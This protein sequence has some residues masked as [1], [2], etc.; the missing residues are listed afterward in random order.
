MRFIRILP[1]SNVRTKEGAR[2]I[3]EEC[4]DYMRA[5]FPDGPWHFT[6]VMGEE[7]L[8]LVSRTFRSTQDDKAMRWLV[9]ELEQP[10]TAVTVSLVK[11]VCVGRLA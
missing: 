10:R 7:F 2:A 8:P 5:A 1:S 4:L 3:A 9:R 6:I 11:N